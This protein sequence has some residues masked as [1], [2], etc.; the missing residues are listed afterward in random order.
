MSELPETV[1]AMLRWCARE[2]AD[3]IA[4]SNFDGMGRRDLSYGEWEAR[5]ARVAENLAGRGV[6][7]DSRVVLR[8]TDDWIAFGVAYIAIQWVG[9]TVVPVAAAMGDSRIAAVATQSRAVG[10]V[11]EN[12]LAGCDGWVSSLASL[13]DGPGQRVPPPAAKPDDVAEIVYTSGTTGTPKGVA[14]THR[15][16]LWASR[17][18]PSQ[19]M[20]ARPARTVMHSLPAGSGAGQTLLLQ[21]L[22]PDPHRLLALPFSP[23]AYLAAIERH[24]PSELLV[25][26]AQAIALVRAARE[27]AYDLTSV[28]MVRNSGAAISPATLK[29]LAALFP[30]ASIANL[31]SSTEAWPA[32]VR[33]LFDPGRPDSV[34]RPS[35]GTHLRVVRDGAEVSAGEVGD[36]EIRAIGAPS[37]WYDSDPSGTAAVFRADGWVHTGDRGY[38]DADGYL[39]L[40]GRDGEI[41]NSG[42]HNLSPIEIEAAIEQHP[43]VIEACAYGV[44]H[45]ALGEY[46]ACAVRVGREINVDEL[47]DWSARRL[48]PARTPKRIHVVIDFPRTVTGKVI[49]SELA[50]RLTDGE[51][52]PGG[53]PTLSERIGRIWATALGLDPPIDERSD[54]LELGG[55]SLEAAEVTTEVREL[56]SLAVRERDLYQAR[57]LHD[58]VERVL[59]ADALPNEDHA[60]T[61][62]SPAEPSR[63]E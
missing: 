45:R 43:D 34:G 9:G 19:G 42:G 16:L 63:A 11:S 7:R 2:R 51:G 18:S 12:P 3:D 50:R 27:G 47:Y 59:R 22:S 5:S 14:A 21:S 4:I 60:I 55:T 13:E 56:T 29:D 6:R 20:P 58:Y 61:R 54:F 8:C 30:G 1:P 24:Q 10:L 15:N 35:R 53:Q 44:P 36:V 28:R 33:I 62:L 40:A 49:K 57:S 17:Q 26:P 37:R 46:V 48:G 38:L 41:I 39:Y 23:R 32:R 25:V 52:Q 31:Y